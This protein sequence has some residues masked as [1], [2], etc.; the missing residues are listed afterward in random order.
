MTE[1][2]NLFSDL[3][4]NFS[5]NPITDDVS[6]KTDD[7]AVKRAIRN[8]LFLRKNEKPFHPEI[9][10]GV[11]DL[12]FETPGPVMAVH[13]K[14]KIEEAIRQ[15][16]PRIDKLDIN[17]NHLPNDNTL[18]LNIRFTIINQKAIYETN[19]KLERTR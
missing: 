1:S 9:N 5:R 19:I 16:E 3:D 15:Y 2:S 12:L 18:V 11:Y 7:D 14:R 13:G 6:V 17:Y 10:P 4:L 8:L